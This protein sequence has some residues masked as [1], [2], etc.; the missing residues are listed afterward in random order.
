MATKIDWK[1]AAN[2]MVIGEKVEL[3]SL[4]GY[5]VQ[6]RRYTKQGEAEIL[7]AQTRVIANTKA[8]SA[9]LYDEAK[10][11]T[12]SDADAIADTTALEKEITA[13]IIEN[14]SPEMVGR[15]EETKA[16][17]L[18]GIAA[19]NFTKEGIPTLDWVNDVMEYSPIANEILA[20]VEDYNRPLLQKVSDKSEM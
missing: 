1:I 20:I 3:K 8:L 11:K 9:A 5:W 16:K 13:K 6:P 17:I 15:L 7:A 2:R 4:P 14:V 10:R 12:G 19:H 18:L